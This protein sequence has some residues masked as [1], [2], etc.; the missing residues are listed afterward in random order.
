V[1]W[2]NSGRQY[3]C[4]RQIAIK[5]VT[6]FFRIDFDLCKMDLAAFRGRSFGHGSH[7]CTASQEARGST[8]AVCDVMHSVRRPA[9][10]DSLYLDTLSPAEATEPAKT[11]SLCFLLP[12][13][14]ARE[15]LGKRRRIGRLV[16]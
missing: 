3:G 9:R 10:A 16:G 6:R 12:R 8:S 14:I 11:V 4:C 2:R 13:R 1:F 7:R 5:E 15:A